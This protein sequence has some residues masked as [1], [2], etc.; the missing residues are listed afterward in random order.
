MADPA[1]SVGGSYSLGDRWVCTCSGSL[2]DD[3]PQAGLTRFLFTHFIQAQM[4]TWYAKQAKLNPDLFRV[5]FD[6]NMR[7]QYWVHPQVINSLPHCT[8]V[9]ALANTTR[10][11]AHLSAWLS[12]ELRLG[13][14]EACWDFEEP[15]RRLALLGCAT[16][17][18]FASYAG[19]AA[20]WPRIAAT[21]G[22]EDL[23]EIKAALG[24]EAHVF[25]LRRGRMIVPEK[26]TSPPAG[27]VPLGEHALD[28]GWRMLATAVI[29]DKADVRKRFV[30]KM[31]PTVARALA[32]A[33]PAPAEARDKAWQ[34]LR[35][36][37]P[38][39]LTE[40]ESQCFA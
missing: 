9:Q 1:A 27:A 18:K 35:K 8:V 32:G 36:I 7:P 19:A 34:R 12:R 3:A 33:D 13:N 15:R 30:L 2:S 14:G 10:G 20:C 22:R 17:N 6:F 11:S 16:L 37:S 24:D 4:S 5:I 39:V 26:E 21:I 23:K 31:P 28:V 40:G 29:D 38:E 25:A